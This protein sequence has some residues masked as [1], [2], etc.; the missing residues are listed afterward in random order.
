[1]K[2]SHKLL[3][4]AN[5]WVSLQKCNTPTALCFAGSPIA[6]GAIVIGFQKYKQVTPFFPHYSRVIIRAASQH[7]A[8][9][10]ICV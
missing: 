3:S 5:F 4:D 10:W 8:D 2:K 1:M 7:C 6:A 9:R